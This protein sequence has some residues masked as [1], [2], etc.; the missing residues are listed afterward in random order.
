MSIAPS[1]LL[2]P[3]PQTYCQSL[4]D[5]DEDDEEEMDHD[6]IL[7]D[8]VFEAVDELAKAYG[9]GFASLW[10]PILEEVLKYLSPKRP[11]SDHDMALG[12]LAEVANQMGEAVQPFFSKMWPAMMQVGIAMLIRVVGPAPT[13]VMKLV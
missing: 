11:S 7:M 2:L 10:P 12:T 13:P 8:A 6:Q 1:R 5:D 3:T 9:A 4:P